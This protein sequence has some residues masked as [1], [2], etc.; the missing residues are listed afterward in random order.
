[1]WMTGLGK[2]KPLT[3]IQGTVC[4]PP[5]A[6]GLK[7]ALG[8]VAVE[9]V[10]YGALLSTNFLPGGADPAG[11]RTM[12]GLINKAAADCPDSTLLVGGCRS[13]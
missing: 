3:E 2:C 7:S 12:A 4:G 13:V 9:G 6:N 5:T 11:I 8:N 10:D 1:M